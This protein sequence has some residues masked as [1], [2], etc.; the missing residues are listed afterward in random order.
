MDISINDCLWHYDISGAADGR[1]V[2]FLHGWGCTGDIFA[3]ILKG[4]ER[5]RL[6]TLDF[7][8]HGRSAV[9]PVPWGVGEYAEGVLRLLDSLGIGRCVVV[10]HSFGG[11]VALYLASRH[12]ERID[13]LILCGCAGIR[14]KADPEKQKKADA[15]RRRKELLLKAGR[16]P[17]MAGVTEKLLDALRDKY[18]S[19]DYKAL[20]PAMRETFVRVISEDLTPLLSQIKAPTL[21]IW[22]ELDTETPLWMGQTMEKEIPDAGLVVFEGDDHFAFLKQYPRFLKIADAFLTDKA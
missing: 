14:P 7:P 3:P 16:L 20:V 22:G 1:T 10:A 19:A 9:P 8:G 18:G 4:M 2:L 17:L 12:P 21:L 5:F 11:R 6:V 15:Y 13:K